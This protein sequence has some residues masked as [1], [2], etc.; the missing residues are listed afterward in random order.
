MRQVHR[1]AGV[2]PED[3]S[4]VEAHGTG[5]QAGDPIECRALGDALGAGRDTPLPIGSVKSNLGHLESG[6]GMAGLLKC[7]LMLRNGVI[8]ASLH[9]EPLNPAIDFSGLGLKPVTAPRPGSGMPR[10]PRPG[11]SR[12]GAA[13][14]AGPYGAPRRRLGRRRA[15]GHRAERHRREHRNPGRAR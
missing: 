7:V 2:G 14:R 12:G 8:P 13:A 1:H 15:L 9:A 3:V 4:Y 5:T 11:R 6:A 10:P